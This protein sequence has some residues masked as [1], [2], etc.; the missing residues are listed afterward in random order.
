MK[1]VKGKDP[2]QQGFMPIAGEEFVYEMVLKCLLLPGAIG[3]S[4]VDERVQRGA[5]M[6]KLPEQFRDLLQGKLQL[7]EDVGQKLAQWA[8]GAPASK[9][10]AN[11]VDILARYAACSDPATFRAL[12]D[13]RSACWN[14]CTKEQKAA[15]KEAA[16]A[17][18]DRLQ[19]ATLPPP[20]TGEVREPG[21][22][23]DDP[24]LPAAG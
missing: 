18:Q 22:D 20:D 9:P 24:S 5:V 2:E 21:V 10:A 15:L 19:K 7:S 1:I 6:I 3:V 4:D 12:E 17:T 13:E 14:S 11:P 8:A 16:V 23:D